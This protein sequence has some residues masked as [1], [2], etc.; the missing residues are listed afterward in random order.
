[1][2]PKELTAKTIR[3]IQNRRRLSEREFFAYQKEQTT[4]KKRK[5]SVKFGGY[6]Y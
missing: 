4:K 2:T 3:D 6:K 1:M 5:W